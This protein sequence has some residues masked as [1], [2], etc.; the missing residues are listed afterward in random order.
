[1]KELLT[2]SRDLLCAKEFSTE[3]LTS[4]ERHNFQ[5]S[6]YSG[7]ILSQGS[8]KGII[9]FEGITAKDN[10]VAVLREHTRDRIVGH[11]EVSISP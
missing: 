8:W 4:N 6:G 5:I 11:G 7:A 1:M 9:D 3:E 10:R 2:K